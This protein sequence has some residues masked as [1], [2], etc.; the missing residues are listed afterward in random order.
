MR[1]AYLT[2]YNIVQFCGWMA[3]LVTGRLDLLMFFQ[4]LQMIE[5]LHCMIGFVKSS[6]FQTFMQIAS[7]IVIVWAAIV[8]YPETRQTI[9]YDMIFWAWP[10]AETTRYIYYALNLMKL[11]VYLVTWA[12]YTLFIVLYPLGVSGELLILYKLLGICRKTQAWSYQLPNSLNISFYG[13]IG[14]I[15]LMIT[16][17]PCKYTPLKCIKSFAQKLAQLIM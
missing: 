15:I 10:I 7:R 11:N 8:P 4:T 17:I 6:A 5:V 1:E 13:D 14:I 9:G 2:F 3:A 12:R 16:Y